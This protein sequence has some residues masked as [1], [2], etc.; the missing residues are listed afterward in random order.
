[1]LQETAIFDA[2]L[3]EYAQFAYANPENGIDL[4]RIF[5]PQVKVNAARGDFDIWDERPAYTPVETTLARHNSPRKIALDRQL[6]TYRCEPH[7]IATE[8]WLPELKQDRGSDLSEARFRTLLSAQFVSRNVQARDIVCA[9]V[10]AQSGMGNWTADDADIIDE[11]DAL[12][13]KVEDKTYGVSPN[14][15]VMSKATWRIIRNHASVLKR[16][17]GLKTHITPQELTEMLINDNIELVITNDRAHNYK[18]GE[19]H[20]IL[21]PEVFA[22]YNA[23]APSTSDF[24][25]AKEFDLMGGPEVVRGKVGLLKEEVDVLWYTDRHICK[26]SSCARLTV[27]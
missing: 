6:G 7:A 1:M 2:R 3:T 13:D 21:G 5:F 22:L 12:I 17:Q 19:A 4:S 14:K 24:S 27:S 11:L 15:L 25:F 8:D 20:N 23:P 26:P 18:T 10:Q 9:A 16:A